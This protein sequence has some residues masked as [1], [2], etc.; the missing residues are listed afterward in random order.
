LLRKQAALLSGTQWTFY[1]T[2]QGREVD[3]VLEQG[4]RR[5]GIEVKLATSLSRSDFA[6]LLDMQ[7]A[8][9]RGARGVLLYLGRGVVPIGDG[10][11]AAPLDHP[12]RDRDLDRVQKRCAHGTTF[13]NRTAPAQLEFAVPLPGLLSCA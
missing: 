10:L 2:H 8:C 12:V 7:A 5:L 13:Q 11:I 1:R 4:K 9:G 6:G 3:F